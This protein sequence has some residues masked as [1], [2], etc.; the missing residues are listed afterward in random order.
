MGW[1]VLLAGLA[2][3][4]VFNKRVNSQR[5]AKAVAVI[6]MLLA[7]TAGCGLA[8]TV[9]GKGVAGSVSFVGKGA[10]DLADEPDLVLA[11]S[12]AVTIIMV[13]IAVADISFDKQA[14]KGAQ[15]AAVVMPTLLALVIGG[16]LGKTGGDAVETVNTKVAAFV[17]DLGES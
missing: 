6:T 9:V 1:V 14:D 16:S 2:T 3:L 13:G 7:A 8:H 10:A 15:F 5:N 11:V 17:S 12:V 4:Y